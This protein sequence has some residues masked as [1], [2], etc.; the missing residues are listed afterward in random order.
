MRH[1]SPLRYPGGKNKLSAFLAKICIDNNINGHYVEPYSG[2]A[3]VALYLLLEDYV[4]K[5]TINDKDRSIYAFWYSA[6]YRNKQLC[7]L[8]ENTEITIEEWKKQKAVQQNKQNANLLELGF[9]TLFLNRTN[10]SGIISAGVIGGIEQQGNYLMDCRFNKQEIINRIK[11]IAS[12]KKDIRL[13]NKDALKLIDKIQKEAVDQNI[14]FYF[15]PPYYYKAESLYMN[16]FNEKT[17][18]KVSDKIKSIKDIKW[19]VSYDNVR[20][21]R[22][23]YDTVD[24]KEYSFKHTAY[25]SRVGQ[26]ILFFSERL[27][28]PNNEEDWN[29]VFYKRKNK[30]IIYK[31]PKEDSL[32]IP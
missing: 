19:I 18:R 26:E 9:S 31:K 12:R 16:H 11:L 15:D 1:Y 29:P 13:F 4:S 20:E 22:E 32:L 14:L 3:S 7:A 28:R 5:I 27:I 24:C 2:G 17:H 8:I 6:L 10:R 21:I 30:K 25:S 23:L